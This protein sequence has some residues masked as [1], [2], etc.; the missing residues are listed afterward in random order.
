MAFV[1]LHVHSQYSLLDGTADV[2]QLAKAAVQAGFTDLALTDTAN[3]YGAVSFA[4]ACKAAGLHPIIGA[5]LHVQPEGVAFDDNRREHGGYQLIALVEDDIGY[6]N[7]CQLITAGIFEGMKYKPRIDHEL[8]RRHNEGLIF[9]TGGAKGVI[10]RFLERSSGEDGALRAFQV[11]AGFLEPDQLYVELCDVGLPGDERRNEVSRRIA[12]A[13]GYPMV[14]TNAVHYLTPEE[15]AI[16]EVLH[17]ISAGASLSDDRR[18]LCP[19]DQAWLKT[20][21]DMRELF[22]ED[23]EAIDATAA[24]AARCHFKFTFG[25]YH[26]PAT[27]PPDVAA[28]GLPEPDTFANWR[29]FYLAFPPPRDFGLPV[30]ASVA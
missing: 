21:A 3:L 4:K 12:R 10:G 26:F 7:L 23:G 22:P 13:T 14:V 2:G 19:T 5:E 6:Y 30:P 24:I 8:L 18:V 25:Q 29:Y 16:H 9:L 28:A 11:L 17:A 20:E 1:H 27:T 15:S